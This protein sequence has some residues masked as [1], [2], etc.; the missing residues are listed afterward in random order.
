MAG[1]R[2]AQRL[3]TRRADGASK[4]SE[5]LSFGI[6]TP[7]RVNAVTFIAIIAFC[8]KEVVTGGLLYLF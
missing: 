3:V 2:P 4:S 8:G 5:L 6:S 1:H 7:L